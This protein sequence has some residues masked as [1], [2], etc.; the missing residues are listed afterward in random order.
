MSMIYFSAD[1][2]FD[3]RLLVGF[4]SGFK[5]LGKWLQFLGFNDGWSFSEIFSD[6]AVVVKIM[7]KKFDRF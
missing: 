1:D 6:T 4:G 3:T 5:I 2:I 7:R